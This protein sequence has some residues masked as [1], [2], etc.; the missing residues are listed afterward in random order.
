M[1]K[2]L[3]IL[4]LVLSISVIALSNIIHIPGQYSTIQAG[5]NAAS[6]GDTVLVA[7][8]V[9][10]G[11]GNKNLDFNGR[12]IVVKSENGADF[13]II[14]CQPS[15]RGFYFH[16]SETNDAVAEGF[17][18]ING[19]MCG[20]YIN[21]SNPTIKK[22]IIRDNTAD[23]ARGGGIRMEFSQPI[24]SHCV[25]SNNTASDYGGALHISSSDATI[26]NCTIS[27]NHGG[28]HGGGICIWYSSPTIK[29]S[30]ISNNHGSGGIYFK[31]AAG[32]VQY[33][34]FYSN[35]VSNFTG[36]VPAGLGVTTYINLNGDLCDMNRNIFMDPLFITTSGD[37]AYYLTLDSPCIDAGDPLSPLDPDGTIADMGAYYAPCTIAFS[38]LE[39][40]FPPTAIGME[41]FL[42]LTIYNLQESE[43]LEI[44]SIT[45]GIPEIFSSDWN[46]A[47]SLIAPGDSLE[48]FIGFAPLASIL[49]IDQMH[50]ENSFYNYDISLQGVEANAVITLIL[51]PHVMNIQI[52]PGGGSFNFD[53]EINN[54]GYT[55]N[56]NFW[57][58]IELPSGVFL[59][60]LVRNNLS[61]PSAAIIERNNIQQFIPAG[62][63]SGDYMYHAYLCNPSTYEIVAH[64]SIPFMKVPGFDLP[65]HNLGWSVFGWDGDEAPMVIIPE[66]LT[67]FEPYPNPFNS[68]AH[69][70]FFLPENG[71]VKLLIYDIQGR[72]VVSLIDS[73]LD[74]GVHEMIWDAS[75]MPSGVYFAKLSSDKRCT[76]KK[77][78]LVM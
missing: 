33:C 19:S 57:T 4:A 77:L 12:I 27:N 14:D 2:H 7:D 58:S 21:Q 36:T 59:P 60:Q 49:Y 55:C 69:L 37:S 1:F 71:P 78:A 3:I 11:T 5:I 41:S 26:K 54:P 44:Y 23:D 45:F 76:I 10:T 25:F 46:I 29:N 72:E 15:G 18:I 9:Y 8:G 40:T 53:L 17:S 61:I 28:N 35:E 43:E 62:A 52:P 34:D 47:D 51:Y 20:I 24:I 68:E 66:K 31:T 6:T 73:H 56:Y 75:N 39:M 42:P 30:I 50:I 22:C 48:L 32:V 65:N 64:D 16:S 63:P 70:S 67:L 74:S 13:C 38:T